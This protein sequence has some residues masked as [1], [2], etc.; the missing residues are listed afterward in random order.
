MNL[1]YSIKNL[2]IES[3]IVIIICILLGQLYLW[4]C[5]KMLFYSG[6]VR[7]VT[8][9]IFAKYCMRSGKESARLRRLALLPGRFA[10][11]V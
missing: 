5:L 8:S 1:K 9:E 6:S 4:Q 7:M 2:K 3:I 10:E 11:I